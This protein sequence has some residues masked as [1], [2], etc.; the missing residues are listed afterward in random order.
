M[1]LLFGRSFILFLY[2]LFDL[3]CRLTYPYLLISYINFKQMF[4]SVNRVEIFTPKWHASNEVVRLPHSALCFSYPTCNIPYKVTSTHWLNVFQLS[5]VWFI[6]KKS[7]RSAI[8]IDT[9]TWY[10]MI[11]FFLMDWT[12][13]HS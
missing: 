2:V 10:K 7:T 3:V 12:I 13:F 11:L 1:L 6:M 9:N 5:Q 4:S 8:L